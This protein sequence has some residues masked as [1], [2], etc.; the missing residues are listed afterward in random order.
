MYNIV[1]L[2]FPSR[3]VTFKFYLSRFEINNTPGWI[4]NTKNQLGSIKTN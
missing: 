4:K 3:E 1:S 2:L